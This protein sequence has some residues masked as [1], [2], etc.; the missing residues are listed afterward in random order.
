MRTWDADVAVVGLGA[1]GS[2]ALWQ[3]ATRDVDAIGVEQFTPGHPWGSS[4]G[5][6]RMFRVTCLEHPGLVPLA[7][8]SLELWHALGDASGEELFENRG[9]LLI[10]PESGRVVGGTLRASARHGIPVQRLTRDELAAHHPLHADLGPDDIGIWEPSAGIL[11]PEAAVR[12]ATARARDAGAQILTGTRVQEVRPVP[13]GVELVTASR[14]LRVR[15]AVLTVGSWLGAHLPH[16]ALT[17]LR[18]PLTWFRPRTPDKRFGIDDLPVFMRELP[19][20][21]IL[22][23]NGSEGPHDVKLGLEALGRTPRP[24]D[25]DTDDRATVQEDWSDLAAV[26]ATRLPGLEP[27]P[28]KVSVCMLTRTRD[29]QFVLGRPGG[30]PRL[31]LAGGCNAH[32]FKHA[33]GIGEALADMVTGAPIR[34]PLD[35]T[36][37][38]RAALD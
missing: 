13:D 30:D 1:W 9:G 3:L 2:S 10:G 18:M 8:R 37:P 24:L 25:P 35:F 16:L 21:E 15:Q 29:G 23:G 7:R 19:D 5:G 6:S 34:M 20:G 4:H 33:T 22:W 26:L 38:D 14:T 31:V 27:A 17:T 32:G 12:A 11:R 28:A 36:D